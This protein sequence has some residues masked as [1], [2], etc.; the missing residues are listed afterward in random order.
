MSA[1]DKKK[2][3]KEQVAE[4]LTAR[5][6]QEQAEAKKLM[7]YTTIFVTIMTI[8]LCLAVAILA[9]RGVKQ[10]GIAQRNTVAATVGGEELS[11]VELSYYY[12]D[13]IQEFYNQWTSQYSSYADSYLLATM[14]LDTTLPLDEQTDPQSGQTWA[15]HFLNEALSTAQND[16]ALYNEAKQNGFTLPAEE[17]EMLDSAINNLDT[18][19]TIYGYT[20]ADKFLQASYGYG[21]SAKSYSAYLERST[22]ADAYY[23]FKEESFTYDDAALREFEKDNM[24]K[25]NSYT[26]DSVYM[27]YTAFLTGGT[28]NEEGET[29]YTDEERDAARAAVKEAA[30]KLATATTLEELKTLAAEIE[31]ADAS[32]VAVSE[33]KDQLYTAINGDLSAWLAED[34]RQDGDIATIANAS[35]STDEDG[36]E[37]TT[38]NGYYVALFHSVNDNKISTS[39]VRHLLVKFPNGIEDE[40]TGEIVYTDED[41]AEAKELADGYLQEWKAGEA[42]EESFIQLVKDHSEDTSASEGGLFENIHP[43]SS[44]V[45]NFLNWS[46]DANRKAG[47]AEVIETEYGYHVMYY[48]GVS[49]L[50]YRDYMIA[51][52][53]R[54][55][56]VAAWYDALLDATVAAM[57]DTSKMDLGLT[58]SPTY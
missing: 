34:A 14:G 4:Q 20:N 16:Y 26:Y 5:Q 10:S 23:A 17:Q 37:T 42:T 27:S 30:D 54:A 52:E 45:E 3:R 55:L 12:V 58:L 40:E 28:T 32:E 44:Y 41:K 53:K 11:S 25:Y 46:I 39:N 8:V 50:N 21:S 6:R 57:G 31:T 13:Y 36:N 22:I 33:N 38:I 29:T 15:Q 1:S 18:Y 43:G 48:V 24:D 47:D 35:T 49:E 7:L 9:V 19:A 51:E 56:D 2:L